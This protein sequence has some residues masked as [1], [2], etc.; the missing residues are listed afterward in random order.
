[1]RLLES[2]RRRLQSLLHKDASNIA[3]SE[4]LRY[5][6]GTLVQQNIARGMSPAQARIAANAEFGNIAQVTEASYESRG[7]ALVDDLAQDIRYGL[8][9][10]RRQPAFTFVTVLTLALGIGACTAIF[11]LVNAVMLRSLPY[12]DSSR[13]V[14]L[15]T[16]NP[17]IKGLPGPEVFGPSNADFFDIK[18]QSHSYEST[19]FFNQKIYSLK[20]GDQPQRVGAAQIDTSFF[21]TLDAAP[22]IGRDF[23]D[24]DEEPGNNHVVIIG[25]PFWQSLFA[26]AADVLNRSVTLN[27]QTYRI[28]GVMPQDFGYPHKTE[29]AYG[30]GRIETTQIWTPSALTAQQ[31]ADRDRSSS[32]ALARLKPDVTPKEAQSE[33]SAIMGR[34]DPLHHGSFANGWTGMVKSFPEHVLGPVRPL[35]L[36]LLAA[37]GFVLLIA[38]GNAANLLLARAANRR[39]ELGVRATLGARRGRLLRQMLTE[40]LLLGGAA[41]IAGVGL[42]YVFIRALLRL[43]PGNIPH[44]ES[45]SL[46]LRALAFLVLISLITSIVFGILPSLSATRINLAEFLSSAGTRG[47]VAD[48]RRLRCILVIVQVALVVV[49]LTG[50]GLFL[51]SYLNVLSVETGFSASTLAVNVA[52]TPGYDSVQKRHA[53]YTTL[54]ERV[55]AQHGIESAGMVNFLPLTDSE[56]LTTLWV[57]GYP[58]QN[59]QLIEERAITSG[60]LTAMQTPL[61]KGRNFTVEEDLPGPHAVVIVNQAFAD[62]FFAGKDAIGQHLR[63]NTADPWSTVIGV[64]QDIRNESLET[65]AVPQIYDP[66]LNGDHALNGAF[67]AMRSS[68]PQA[69]TISAI[70]AAV[71]SIDP[72]LAISDIHVMSDLTS[73]AIAPRRFQTTLLTLFSTIALFLAVVGVYGL[74]AYSVRQRTGEIGLRMALGSTRSGIARLILREGLSLLITGLCLGM[75]AATAFARLLRSF[76]YEVPALDPITFALVPALLLI[77][78]LAACLIPSARA[79]ATDPMVALRHE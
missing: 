15:F 58:N 59:R 5:H 19:T 64:A 10:L 53:F 62:K 24:Q 30:N 74:L 40:S 39:H 61:L 57:E 23:N 49:L 54:L 68:L 46:D 38:C 78:T 60:Y 29:L 18:A 75:A 35:M 71:R 51:H 21:R 44:M 76:L 52:I 20:A 66:F 73:H 79:A 36:L 45:A 13:L 26:G 72:G 28:V 6:L 50:A 48:R 17:N 2:L 69:A 65:A 32:N 27:E 43:D 41:G 7:T 42:A 11:S 9:S 70:R 67:V 37:V 34:L 33:L 4:E 1:M 22:L 25:Y 14:Y 16:P 47:L 55:G 3:L 77:A 63:R 12:G 8:R 56:S 31:M